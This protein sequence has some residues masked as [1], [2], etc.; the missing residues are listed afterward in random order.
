[1]NCFELQVLQFEGGKLVTLKDFGIVT[2]GSDR[3]DAVGH[4]A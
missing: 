3:R 4:V 2:L 1:M